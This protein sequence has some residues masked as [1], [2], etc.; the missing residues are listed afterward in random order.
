M[1]MNRF[2]FKGV[3]SAAVGALCATGAFAKETSWSSSRK[4]DWDWENSANFT[5]GKP[6]NGDTV[7]IPEQMTVYLTNETAR[8]LA[9]KLGFIKLQGMRTS[10]SNRGT[11]CTLV[12]DVPE[13]EYEF[14]VPL[15]EAADSKALGSVRKTGAGTL[16]MKPL[17]NGG[18]NCKF[19]YR[20]DFDVQEG[21]LD[22]QGLSNVAY[23]FG[24][25]GIEKN[26]TLVGADSTMFLH[27]LHGDGMLTN[28]N[29]V[30]NY[31]Y[32]RTVAGTKSDPYRFSGAMG[33]PIAFRTYGAQYITGTNNTHYQTGVYSTSSKSPGT[34][35]V[36]SFGLQN[37]VAS[38]MGYENAENIFFYEYGGR[39]VYLGEG[40]TTMKGLRLLDQ[41]G[42]GP[43]IVNG[44]ENGGLVIAGSFGCQSQLMTSV[45]LEGNHRNPCVIGGMVPSYGAS[46]AKCSPHFVKRGSG[47]W[48]F[49]GVTNR[50]NSTGFTIEEGVLQFDDI[51]EKGDRSGLGTAVETHTNYFGAFD[52]NA[53]VPWAFA[54]GTASTEGTLEYVGTNGAYSTGRTIGLVGAG[55]LSCASD[56]PLRFSGVMP[57]GEGAKVFTLAGSGTNENTIADIADTEDSPITVVKEG[58]GN[59]ILANTNAI[60]GGLEVKAG[61]LVVRNPSGK[62]DWFR[63]TIR[64]TFGLLS[65]NEQHVSASQFGLY[66]ENLNR[67]NCGWTHC[68]NYA[69]IAPGQA[70]HQSRVIYTDDSNYV[71]VLK[72][73]ELFYPV[74]NRN[75]RWS[76]LL[77]KEIKPASPSTHVRILMRAT[78]GTPEVARYDFAVRYNINNSGYVLNPKSWCLEGSRDGIHWDMLHDMSTTNSTMRCR[79]SSYYYYA[80]NRTSQ[81]ASDDPDWP[82]KYNHTTTEAA[83]EIAG[84]TNRNVNVMAGFDYVKVAEGAE[85]VADGE[86]LEISSL[87]IDPSGAGT[88]DGFSF[89]ENGTLDVIGVDKSGRVELPGAYANVS[90]FDNIASWSLTVDGEATRRKIKV[91]G[92]TIVL[93]NP[94]MRVI[95]R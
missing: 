37:K 41:N 22:M 93:V 70:A 73:G 25:L 53:R 40:E 44:G 38:S 10:A 92:N 33:G 23:R 74:T 83:P 27:G 12:I 43:A 58:A 61:R 17:S 67:V 66:D 29:E 50:N 81:N 49:E 55:R 4:N 31:F 94:G 76:M 7:V 13:G 24:A 59:W 57:V 77:P 79:T 35:G 15:H 28:R 84:S 85:L 26:A 71:N 47:T 68:D 60:H 90:G 19:S 5:N 8:V 56:S 95:L 54:L 45:I 87:R 64:Q 65:G 86:G 14:G 20:V 91:E 21:V 80:A 1:K 16:V 51:A 63:W 52:A 46:G 2:I 32:Y 48:R 34:L 72:L 88:I 11:C 9:N 69:N 30:E 78:N 42:M 3:V 6:E 62:Y 18:D 36:G 82:E 89:A 75:I 39:I